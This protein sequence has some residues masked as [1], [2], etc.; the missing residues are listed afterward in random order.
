MFFPEYQNF[1]F[2]FH[3]TVCGNSI[4]TAVAICLY[5]TRGLELRDSPKTGRG[6]NLQLYQTPLR[7]DFCQETSCS[8]EFLGD[9]FTVVVFFFHLFVFS[10][11]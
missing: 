1:I 6:Q 4:A 7:G 10:I 9:R 3:C 5:E 2:L 8:C 11:F